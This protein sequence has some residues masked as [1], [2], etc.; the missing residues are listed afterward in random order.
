MFRTKNMKKTTSISLKKEELDEL[1]QV[2][3]LDDRSRSQVVRAAIKAFL[4]I[5]GKD[6]DKNKTK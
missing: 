5:R 4:K 1:D 3:K 2:A 6:G